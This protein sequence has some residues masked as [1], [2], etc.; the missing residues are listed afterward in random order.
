[1]QSEL[2]FPDS[3]THEQAAARRAGVIPTLQPAEFKTRVVKAMTILFVAAFAVRLALLLLLPNFDIPIRGEMEHVAASWAAT[4]HLADPYSTPTGPTAHVAPLYAVLLGMLYRMFGTGAE[5][6]FAQAVLAC[7]LSATRSALLVPVCVLLGLSFR[8]GMTAGVLSV[9]YITAFN[10]EVRGSWE[11][12]LTGL[13][14]IALTAIAARFNDNPE[15]R[16]RTAFSCGAFAGLGLLLSPTLI[17]VLTAYAL[18]TISRGWRAPRRYAIWWTVTCST[19][20]LVVAPWLIRNQHA[21]GSPVLRSNFGLELSLAYNNSEDASA[22]D[23]GITESHPLLNR[24]VS[25]HVAQVGEISFNREREEQAIEW[26]RQHP[27]AAARLFCEHMVYFWFP[28]TRSIPMRG[29]L[30]VVTILAFLGFW[31]LRSSNRLA[32]KL[33]GLIWLSFPLV[34]YITYWSSRYRYPIEWTLLL[35]MAVALNQGWKQVSSR[36]SASHA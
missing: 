16:L 31:L 13:F 10:T 22:L 14:L 12:P 33:L 23:P 26:I 1:M 24:A 36:S 8:T 15:F 4:G 9:A 27:L 20:L 30:A 34:Y 2:L 19:A 35:C 5:G 28:P 25:Q 6:H 7:T 17:P 29:I 11:A 3:G 18:W 21:L 32:A